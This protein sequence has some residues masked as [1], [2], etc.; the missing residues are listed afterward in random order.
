MMQS[1]LLLNHVVVGAEKGIDTGAGDVG[2]G[3]GAPVHFAVGILNADVSCCGSSGTALLNGVLGVDLQAV[4]GTG[5]ALQGVADGIQ[6]TVAGGGD[7][8]GDTVAE[9]VTVAFTVSGL[10]RVM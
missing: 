6:R 9:E 1:P 2:V 3:A 8:G 7:G 5:I 10:E 4:D